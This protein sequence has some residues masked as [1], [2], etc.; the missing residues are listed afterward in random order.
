MQLFLRALY[1]KKM[2]VKIDSEDGIGPRLRVPPSL[3]AGVCDFDCCAKD[4]HP[5]IAWQ[6]QLGFVCYNNVLRRNVRDIVTKALDRYFYGYTEVLKWL[7][8][9]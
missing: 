1:A 9:P 6:E 8:P 2:M 3:L 4:H 7:T 5:E